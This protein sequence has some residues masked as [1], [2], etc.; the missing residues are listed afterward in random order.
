MTN[1][2]DVKA[3]G[4]LKKTVLVGNIAFSRFLPEETV[5]VKDIKLLGFTD[6]GNPVSCAVIYMRLKL[7]KHSKWRNALVSTHHRKSA[8]S[9]FF[10]IG[11]TADEM[12]ASI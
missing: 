5:D 7:A 12:D 3:R 10:E 6:E 11:R 9:A 2:L 1:N 4:L 8:C